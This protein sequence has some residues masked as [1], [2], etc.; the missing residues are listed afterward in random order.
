M[1]RNLQKAYFN[2]MKTILVITDNTRDQ[3]NGVVTTFR[4][5]E[6]HA[7]NDGYKICYITP[8]DFKHFN[9]P[10]YP[11]VKISLPFGIGKR[12]K[13]INPDYIHIATEGPIGF[14]TNLWCWRNHYRFNTSYHS[15]WPEFMKKMYR[16]PENITIAYLKWF[17]N[18]SGIVLTTTKTMVRDLLKQGYRSN[19]IPWTRGVDFTVFNSSSRR[20]HDK[21]GP[22]LLNVG[23]VSIE[24]GLD[25]FCKLDYPA[26]IKIIVGDGPYRSYLESKYP[27]VVF[28]GMKQGNELAEYY[29]NSDVFVFSSIT[30]TFGVVIIESIA[31]GTP[32]AAYR[33]P[34][35]MD[36]LEEGING[37]MSSDLKSAIDA[38]LLLNRDTVEQSSCVWT[39]EECWRIFRDNLISIR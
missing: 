39:W 6:Q 36:I 12:I 11:E 9:A 3:I 30:D 28:V 2:E 5:I 27:D 25:D 23:R 31:C 21:L 38:C 22:V 26:S 15:K 19:I 7:I 34:G 13:Q 14:I 37:A 18:H 20:L 16:I 1:I 29:A 8:N 32:V 4:N 10:G 24:K 35:P 17:H 33:V